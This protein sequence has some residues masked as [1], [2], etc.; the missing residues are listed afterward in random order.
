MSNP[1]PDP[2][3]V[4]ATATPDPRPDLAP[5]PRPLTRFT[6]VGL[7]VVALLALAETAAF[8]S[9]YLLVSSRYVSTD[10]AQVD[11]RAVDIV[12]PADG[13]LTR[14]T[15]QPGETLTPREVVGRIR[16]GGTGPQVVIR[17]PGG[18]T[19]ARSL[20]T[21]GAFVAEGTRLAT[22]YDLGGLYV[23]A[24]VPETDVRDVR[25]GAP[26]DIT[27]DS[28]PD[29]KVAGVVTGVQGATAGQ[30]TIFPN[31]QDDP[32]NPQA[33][34]QYVPVRI[35]FTSIGDADVRPG[36]SVTV[37]IHRD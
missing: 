9:H 7:V 15:A 14:W 5:G 33:T 28:D 23:T 4:A 3:A 35:A 6:K 16:S 20:A 21:D 2:A 18:G 10:N 34:D 8:T 29:A 1:V 17:S 12:A 24:R 32:T 30:F 25:L 36:L 26:V 11:G 37:D 31:P 19:V 22:A 13:V 27:L